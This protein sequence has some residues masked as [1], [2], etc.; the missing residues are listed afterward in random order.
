MPI[1]AELLNRKFEKSGFSGY[2]AADVDQ[3]MA[4]L[5]QAVSKENRETADLRRRLEET[6][7]KLSSYRDM[8]ES[9]KNAMLS[10]QR[11]ADQTAKDSKTRAELILRDAEIKAEKIVEKAEGEIIFRKEEAERIKREVSDFR[12]RMMQMYRQHLELITQLP[13]EDPEA[14]AASHGG[15]PAAPSEDVAPEQPGSSGREPAQP[16][17]SGAVGDD[18]AQNAAEEPEAQPAA[19]AAPAEEDPKEPEHSADAFAQAAAA[20]APEESADTAAPETELPG[21]TASEPEDAKPET[22]AS[23]APAQGTPVIRLNLRYNEKTGEYES[24]DRGGAAPISGADDGL[25]FGSR[26]DIRSG[27]F[28]DEEKGKDRR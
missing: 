16:E 27:R 1:P 2:K 3:F 25:R 26:Y 11:L 8:E 24:V 13:C 21:E 17:N 5:S 10:A 12:R 22:P 28:R 18:A 4:E 14:P 6:E 7:R 23:D 20:S 19:P 15:E 9:L